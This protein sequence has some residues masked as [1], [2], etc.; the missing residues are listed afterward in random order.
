MAKDNIS[1]QSTEN[2]PSQNQPIGSAV[3]VY[4]K[5]E[6][7]APDGTTRLL[8][9]NGPV[10]LGE[11][12]I[13]SS[14]GSI[15]IVFDDGVN[16]QL[17]LGRM[18]D[19]TLDEDVY[20][21]SSE[22]LSEVLAE[23]EDIQE[24]LL[25]GDFDPTIDLE[26]PAAGPT[27][28]PANAGG[29]SSAPRFQLTADEVTPEAGAETT[30][31]GYDFVGSE[32]EFE[33][34]QE[35][36]EEIVEEVTFQEPLVAAAPEADD[37][38]GDD[39][40]E[41][42]PESSVPVAGDYLA[43]LRE[44]NLADG[45]APEAS[46]LNVSGQ[47]S[48]SGTLAAELGVDFGDDTPGTISFGG[49]P[50]TIDN[51]GGQTLTVGG[52]YGNLVINDDGTWTYTLTDNISHPD[53]DPH[54]SD[55]FLSD[56]FT[57]TIT[58]EDGDTASGS[59]T[60]N[61]YD[62]A[63][64]QTEI[65]V[66]RVVEEEGLDNL[67]D[68]I[69]NVVGSDGNPDDNDL[70]V[71]PVPSQQDSA[72]VSG[73][74]VDFVTVGADNPGSFTIIENADLPDLF[75]QGGEVEYVV[76]GDTLEAWVRGS[77]TLQPI[78]GRNQGVSDE[79]P[80]GDRLVFTFKVE[81]SGDYTFTLLDQ[82][83]HVAPPQGVE[84]DEN[85]SLVSTGGI[86]E[87]LDLSKSIEVTDT[88]GDSIV[89]ESGTLTIVI[90]DDTPIIANELPG[91]TV[92][93]D[94]L[95]TPVDSSDG[96]GGGDTVVTYDLSSITKSGA[97]EDLTYG[98][99]EI[100]PGFAT[101]LKSRE[102]DVTYSVSGSTLTAT[103]AGVT[104]FTF[105]VDPATG[106]AT[107]DLDD[108]LDHDGLGD[109][110]T[111]AINNLGQFVTATDADG[112]SVSFDNL[113]TVVVENDVPE[114]TG[115]LESQTV[116]EDGLATPVDSSDGIGGGDTV[117]TYDLSAITKS[118]A[119]E[120]LTY[121]FTAIPPGFAT[122]LKSKTNDV[123]YSVSGSTLTATA[124]G[125]TVFTF[126]V[127]PATGIATFDL[128]D[129]LDH[130]GLG[131]AET[132]AINN[133]GQFVTATD[134]DGDSVSFD[135]LITVVVENDVPEITGK[136][137]SQTVYEDG[138][139]TPVDS[140][141]GIG[142]GDT[143]V[144]Y[145]L[146]AITKSGADEDLTYGFTEIPPGFATGLKSKTNDVT[147]SV[148]GSTLTATAAGVTVFTFSVDPATGI[149]TFDLDDQLDHEGLGDA[150]TLAINNL[151]Q[152]VTATDAD[153]DSVSFDNL[154]NVVV[155]NDVPEI[156][157][158]LESQTV[159]ED[160]LAT[161][162][163]S[164]DGIG[165]GD[166]VVT[167]DL[168]S[169][170]K[171]GA[172]EDLTYG[173]TAIPPGFATGLK[174]REN[175]VTYSVSGS[176]LTATAAGVTVFTFSVD[177]ATGIAT[178]D[179]DDQ[180]DH[181]GLGDAETLAINNLGQF[182][183]ATDADGDSVSFDNL[184]NVVVENDVPEITGK[185]ESQ[186]V[187]EDGLA[188]PVD[189]SDGIGGGDT[190][191]TY[192]LSSITKSGADE[193]LTYGFTAIPPGFATGLKSREN[194]V[195]Y[196]VSGSTL[197]A[198]A[199]GV[200]VFT[201]SVDPATGIATFDLD[202][203]LDHE[204][205]GD[206][207]TLAINNLGQFVTATD[208]DG[209]SVSFDNLIN[210]VVEND[211]PEITG[212]L[213]SQTV[214]EDG[215][216][217]P[218]DSSDG[219][220][221]GDTVVTYDLSSITKS[222][223]DED[224][225]YGFTAIPPGFATG[226]KSK[227]NDVTY[228]VSGSTLTATAAGVTVFTFSVDPATG[229]ATFDLDDQ[230][231][232]DGLGD[233][234]TLAINN[235][236]QF[237][238]ATDA[239]GDSVSFDNLITVVVENDVPEIT[240]KL[241][242]QTV[243]EDG[244]A[245]P[246]DSSDGIGG[247][248]TV[249]TYD[250]SAITKSGADEDLTYGFTAIPPGFATGLKSREND[251]T[252]SVS[253]STLTAT[254]AGVTVFTFSVDPATGIATFDLDDQ[255]D[256][257]G[258]G[259]AETL[260]INNLGQFVTATDADGDS[261]SFDNLINVVVENDVPEIT[262]KLESQTVYEDGLATP[263]DSSDGIGGG[264]TVVTYD[265]SAITKSGADEDLTYGFTEI[266]P[267]FATGLKSKTND[268]TYSVSGSTLTATAAGVTVFT[269]SVDPATGIATFD[270]DDQLD[271]DGLGD[272]ETLAIN[273]LGQF[274]TAT[275]AD[276]DSVSFDNLITVVV[277]NDVPEITGKLE[278]QTVYEDGLATPVDSSDGIGGGDTVVTYDLSAITKSGAD[279]D[280]TYGFTEIPPGFATGLKSKTNDVTYSVSGSTLTATAA[281]VTVFTFS[282]DPATGIATFDLDDQLDHDG[283]GDAETLAI[284]NL[285]QFVTATDADGDSVSFD[286][287]INVVVENDVPE[288][289][290]KL[291]S[292][293]VYEDGL[294]TPVDSS[295]GIGGG[296]TVVTYDLSSITKSGADEDLTYGFTAIP[297]GFAT[298]LK[299]R[300]NDVTYSVSGSTLTATAAGV[301]VFTFSVDPATGIA[302]FDL[303]DQLDHEGLG[304]AET[305]AINNLGQFVTATD[306]DGDSFSFDNLI[307]VVVENDVPE[308]TGKLESQTVY[309]DGL[310]TP[311]DSS[312][313]I[314][315]GDT[316]VTYDLSA[317]TKSGADEDL[318]YGFTAIPPGFAT[319]LKSKTNDVTYSVSGSTLTATAAGVTVFTFSV[320]PATG[321][322]TFDLDDQL[323]H[324]GLGDAETL[325]INNLGQFVT[326]TDADGD[327][328]SFDN[329]INVVVE[330]DVPEIGTV[331]DAYIANEA[332]V[333][334]VGVFEVDEGADESVSAD[335]T[336]NIEGWD[337]ATTFSSVSSHLSGG[338]PVYYYV[339]PSD[340]SVLKAVTDPNDPDGSLVFT[341]AVDPTTDEYNLEMHAPLDSIIEYEFDTSGTS[342]P[343]GPKDF[344]VIAENDDGTTQAYSPSQTVPA[345]SDVLFTLSSYD[346]SGANNV[347]GSSDGMGIQNN[348]V[349]EGE[350]LLVI[351]FGTAGLDGTVAVGDISFGLKHVP[352]SSDL[353]VRYTV[354]DENGNRLDI[355]G[356]II[357]SGALQQYTGEEIVLE[358]SE[359]FTINQTAN[360]GEIS[361]VE[362]EA[363]DNNFKLTSIDFAVSSTET[364]VNE[365]FD[366]IITDSDGDTDEA[367]ISVEFDG[368][369]EMIGTD[370][371][372]AF[373][374]GVEG[375][376]IYGGGGDD[377][378]DGGGGE[379]QI[380][381]GTGADTIDG[382]AGSDVIVGDDAVF[383]ADA[384]S[385]NSDIVEDGEIDILTGGSDIDTIGDKDGNDT[386]TDQDVP[387]ETIED[388]L[389]NLIPPVTP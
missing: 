107:F 127:D 298:G 215:L 133:L 284:N 208:A 290:G 300:E 37:L 321:I 255:L 42:D 216:A 301:T 167:Y 187:Y 313:G 121:G 329:L 373:V 157:G 149:A 84:S 382:G 180:L 152:F 366:V 159:Y 166:T 384:S 269:F 99:T 380:I 95:A 345:S 10:F 117:V 310:A 258:L 225:T 145:D 336:S 142:G 78:Q 195:T 299:S 25:S 129:Q 324:E 63:P 267:G 318:T 118:G 6:A 115:K 275:D 304:D 83:D 104:V 249:V 206:A 188:T 357:S 160:G 251:V 237:V 375:E 325:A 228:S 193:D 178:F 285:G 260:A 376:N 207:E 355:D 359:E 271:H 205:L 200:T 41:E 103:A 52:S 49:A 94:G 278:S 120:D 297:P 122:G 387:T 90:E 4:G 21:E 265:L 77:S 360:L 183:T 119:D 194:D 257:E 342:F 283:L 331:T 56:T 335:L 67:G 191:V 134:A 358:S 93:E 147:Y 5:V 139:A 333:T 177:P 337:G 9:P 364:D 112:D 312:D 276:G 319:G 75:S 196:S 262:G 277:E 204:G 82:L 233:A 234:E 272:A 43:E 303:D 44:E 236:G 212:K 54:S 229:I 256:H 349:N 113:I 295:D 240:G 128:D 79:D 61:I 209:D 302:T 296:D 338:Q 363:I 66:A 210:V 16:S 350:G 151:G 172:D 288:I 130:E 378:I 370:D 214:Y 340:K 273:N 116:Y 281:G 386:V 57:F 356:N 245:T 97:D 20:Q 231:D 374:G 101:G 197:T 72:V 3:I 143:V 244:L 7:L 146:S 105:S 371:A 268:V 114:I 11:R 213:E 226:L 86:V 100:P 186:T 328:V 248:D 381:G 179:L 306:A 22:D 176:T 266:P 71:D 38:P 198:T 361:R 286:N 353:T 218:V 98:F 87:S 314:G 330:N 327:S 31:I 238:T 1:L 164:S 59:L 280:L 261:V 311:V 138:L 219:I 317:I 292:Q 27:A 123:T 220:G 201:F 15:S 242:S 222:G 184:I 305:L 182:V 369:N 28:A 287:L 367:T 323:D 155:E 185:L 73:S 125:V 344:L 60:V 13:T 247:G 96:I 348:I 47:L 55:Q 29:G 89:L 50:L 14:N 171:S 136:L 111:L 230:L 263:V 34:E 175:D 170:T 388:D 347:N 253:G 39:L 326:A 190:V 341:L 181:E 173:F 35:E 76:N 51:S 282:V 18:S 383:G 250:L 124:A 161:P 40:P 351:D 158:K 354:F 322:A 168:S 108:Q 224:L 227:T 8:T 36:Q 64:L 33:E 259:D 252:Y 162:V 189:S 153:G 199:A 389:D 362:L 346:A 372:D 289:T 17:D 144:T 69:P 316:V 140:S 270:L 308:I 334:L 74:L 274:V 141:D 106:I 131:D 80:G 88:D 246:V 223:A 46:L 243:Y 264:D 12:I 132:L 68:G 291:E 379:D 339:D 154:I 45:T 385:G 48:V 332:G 110:E 2:I 165:G 81:P 53:V 62:D 232:H 169:I 293:T 135:N 58:D 65:K 32:T 163:D 102:N 239:D 211:V 23:V 203:Q 294:A 137:E 24:A 26:A 91:Q 92:Y 254:A 309:E 343:G 85:F 315:G 241:E 279:E 352:N 30:G 174:S 202:D 70:K 148:S 307:T 377:I 365:E 192:D 150:E 217:T 320:D 368:D 221:G 126:S 109:A 156:T 19:V 235:L